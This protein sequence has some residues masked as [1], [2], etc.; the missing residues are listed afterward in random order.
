MAC[1]PIPLWR[2]L[3][4]LNPLKKTTI[5]AQCT[6]CGIS[7]PLT[8]AQFCGISIPRIRALRCRYC[9]VQ[10]RK[11]TDPSEIVDTRRRRAA[12]YLKYQQDPFR[13]Y[14]W[15]DDETEARWLSEQ[16]EQKET[17]QCD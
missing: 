8:R 17:E 5:Q 1:T 15:T 9:Q 2:W 14:W 13:P 12:F 16:S 6:L 10:T 11:G 7:I 4:W 3:F